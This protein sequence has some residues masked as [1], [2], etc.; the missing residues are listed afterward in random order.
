MGAFQRM[1]AWRYLRARRSEGFISVIAGFSMVGIALGVGTLIVVMAVMNGFRQELVE[2]VLGLNGH[3][4]IYGNGRA[5]S[6]YEELADEVA[7]MDGVTLVAPVV[8]GQVLV[9][10]RGVASGARVRGVPAGYLHQRPALADDLYPQDV[11]FSDGDSIAIGADMAQRLGVAVGDRMTLISPEGNP[12]PFGT[13]PRLRDYSVVALFDSGMYEYDNSYIYMPLTAAQQFFRLGEAVTTLEV[14][15]DHPEEIADIRT[16]M[17]EAIGTEG[18]VW[19]WQEANTSLITALQVERNVMFLILTLII[20]VAAFNVI[21]GLVMLV[22]DKGRDIAIMRT[23]GASRGM[24]MGV[25]LITGTSIGV[26]GTI[27]G[28]VLGALFADNIQSIQRWIEDISGTQV[29]DPTMRFLTE[30]P[31]RMDWWETGAVVAM[32]LALSFLA[33]LYPSWRAA[34]LDPVEALRYE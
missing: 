19:D 26:V 34:R 21:A 14:F 3:L 33:T 9:T 25:F 15:V 18:R 32:A 27:A 16:R 31:A 29:W 28:F 5:L 22:K 2:R 1:V 24:V 6:D 20:L 12:G 7:D 4:G 17:R 23:M 10:V 11:D 30:M 13:M 8:E